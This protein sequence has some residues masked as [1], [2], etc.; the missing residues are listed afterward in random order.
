MIVEVL[1]QHK[2]IIQQSILMSFSL[3]FWF[4]DP[5]M[6]WFI[7]NE[8]I[9]FVSSLEGQLSLHTTCPTPESLDTVEEN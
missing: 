6:F 8:L 2:V 5:Q 3:S 1:I 9:D 7:L 4:Y